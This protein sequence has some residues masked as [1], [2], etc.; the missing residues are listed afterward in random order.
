MLSGENETAATDV[1]FAL[2][3]ARLSGTGGNITL[4]QN[5]TREQAANIS[6]LS[7]ASILMDPLNFY[8]VRA[9]FSIYIE[10]TNTIRSITAST[11]LYSRSAISS[12]QTTSPLTRS[13]RASQQT[14][15]SAQHLTPSP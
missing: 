8:Q 13:R 9:Q 3:F 5:L 7:A 1:K 15:G 14:A 2:E 12:K 6:N 10:S 4:A 11:H